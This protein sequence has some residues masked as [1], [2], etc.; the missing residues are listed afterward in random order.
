MDMVPQVVKT[1][2]NE[3]SSRDQTWVLLVFVDIDPEN[4]YHTVRCELSLPIG[5][6]E[7]GQISQWS[8]RIIIPEIAICPDTQ[9]AS[10]TEYAPEQEIVLNRKK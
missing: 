4:K 3:N 7:A 10:P 8:E 9:N 6:N 5:M 2:A 1:P